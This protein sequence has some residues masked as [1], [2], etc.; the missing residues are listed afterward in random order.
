MSPELETLDHLI[1]GDLPAPV[2][3][4]IYPDDAAFRRG[5]GGLLHCGDVVLLR[6]SFEVPAWQWPVML[7]G[8]LAGIRFHLTPQGARRIA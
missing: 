6:D 8:D 2:I 3:R 4:Q 7:S 5:A 1:G